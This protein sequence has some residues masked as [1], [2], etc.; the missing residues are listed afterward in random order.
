MR[1][2]VSG[3]TR[4]STVTL[5][6]ALV[7]GSWTPIAMA[8]PA[9]PTPAPT[10]GIE[11]EPGA[12]PTDP[13]VLVSEEPAPRSLDT[14]VLGDF[15]NDPSYSPID[16]AEPLAE[17]APRTGFDQDKST[18]V[19]RTATEDIYLNE[20][21]TKTVVASSTTVNTLDAAGEYQPVQTELVPAVPADV[22]TAG[23]EAGQDDVSVRAELHP[24]SPVF[25]E[26]A[27]DGAVSVEAD[28]VSAMVTPVDVTGAATAAAVSGDETSEVT[29]ESAV[30]GS[31]LVYEVTSGAVKE[32]IVV[33]A[34][35]GADGAAEWSF[36]LDLDG[37][38][39][40]LTDNGSL[41]IHNTAGELEMGMPIPY[42]FDS[43]AVPGVREAN[44]INGHYTL[45]Q[46][47][48][49]WKLTV[50]HPGMSGDCLKRSARPAAGL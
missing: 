27:A 15:S 32:S 23:E 41:E 28:E 24:L 11:I 29:Y 2:G 19:E 50:N 7:V 38:T 30:S 12:T 20:D 9:E 18:V 31:D 25:G 48:G 36:W 10:A 47:D 39:P 16:A 21:G 44:D 8:D 42:V 17:Q 37:G 1:R 26:T 5:A 35:P 4:V 46:V 49:S 13:G 45:E 22:A 6:S 3:W 43:A 34:A 33:D 40:T 14:G